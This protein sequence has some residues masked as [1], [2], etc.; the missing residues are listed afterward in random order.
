MLTIQLYIISFFLPRARAQCRRIPNPRKRHVHE[1]P[2]I[3]QCDG[4]LLA[5]SRAHR[6]QIRT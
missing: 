1:Y 4:I 3:Y 6:A 2:Q 5:S